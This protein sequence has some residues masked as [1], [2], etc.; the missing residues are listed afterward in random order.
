MGRRDLL[1]V[2]ARDPSVIVGALC[3]LA[4]IEPAHSCGSIFCCWGSSCDAAIG[5][6]VR[7]RSTSSPSCA[8]RS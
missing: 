6:G 2:L 5:N 1:A 8:M 3:I 4:A 7:G